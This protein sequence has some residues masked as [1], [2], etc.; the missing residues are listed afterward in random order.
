MGINIMR[1]ALF[2]I[3]ISAFMQTSLS[4]PVDDMHCGGSL[5]SCSTGQGH[6][7]EALIQLR[8]ANML[9]SLEEVQEEEEQ[10]MPEWKKKGKKWTKEDYAAKKAAFADK[11]G[12]SA[13]ED[14]DSLLAEEWHKKKGKKWTKEDYA[15]KKAAFADKKG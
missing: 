13:S 7:K 3:V 4:G 10:A 15:A 6:E 11:K 12:D 2:S 1:S 14:D 5:D 8:R 9:D